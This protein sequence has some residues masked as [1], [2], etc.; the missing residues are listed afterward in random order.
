M[1]LN[2]LLLSLPL[3]AQAAPTGAPGEQPPPGSMLIPIAIFC[4]LFYVMILRPQMKKQKDAKALVSGLKTGDQVITIGGVH[5]MI[6]NV[7][8]N[9]VTV[10]IAENVKVKF[11]R[12]AIDQ[13]LKPSE[14][15]AAPTAPA[16]TEKAS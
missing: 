2:D 7:Q 8:E 6:T 13:V 3:L 4:V 16:T 10:K 11:Q 9:T 12:T 15:K 14:D 5:G 1:I